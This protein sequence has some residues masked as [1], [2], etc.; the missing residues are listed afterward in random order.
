MIR[1]NF[2]FIPINI[3]TKDHL[4][5]TKKKQTNKNMNRLQ[6]CTEKKFIEKALESCL[7]MKCWHY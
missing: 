6:N 1:S 3:G 4:N 2:C 7:N 5:G